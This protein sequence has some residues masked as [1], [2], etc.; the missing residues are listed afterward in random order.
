VHKGQTE[1]IQKEHLK[2]QKDIEIYDLRK[3]LETLR[4]QTRTQTQDLQ[5]SNRA[6]HESQ[7]QNKN[8]TQ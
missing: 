1:F 5:D 6:L 8:L 3:Q 4:S 7:I 2:N